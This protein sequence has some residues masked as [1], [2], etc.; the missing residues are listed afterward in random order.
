MLKKRMETFLIL[1]IYRQNDLKRYC[2][3]KSKTQLTE[4]LLIGFFI[5][6]DD[7]I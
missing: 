4:F 3:Y 1:T 2:I 5:W 7:G 6:V